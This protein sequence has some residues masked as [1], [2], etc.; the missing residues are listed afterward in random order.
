M[1]HANNVSDFGLEK[2]L[3]QKLIQDAQA[4]DN[5]LDPEAKNAL[6]EQIDQL[7]QTARFT[8]NHKTESAPHV[9][10][11]KFGSFAAV[12]AVVAFSWTM[13]EQQQDDQTTLATHHN[14]D[15]V[16][17]AYQP[18]RPSRPILES[19]ILTNEYAAILSDIEK[20]ATRI[21]VD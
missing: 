20:L 3:R 14:Y 10:N 7:S 9:F 8:E 4:F 16:V 18:I 13:T 11:W 15:P 21:R 19:Q 12:L 6:F 2:E 1:K 17:V 5:R